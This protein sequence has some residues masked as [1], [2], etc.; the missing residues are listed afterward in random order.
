MMK[1]RLYLFFIVMV[2]G[3]L[4]ACGSNGGDLGSQS[5]SEESV[6]NSSTE[7]TTFPVTF[8]DGVQNEITI[9]EQPERIISLMPS[10]TETLFA[11]GLNDEIIGVL[12]YDNYPEEATEKEKVGDMEINLEKIIALEPDVVFAHA[13]NYAEDAFNQLHDI[14]VQVVVVNDAT[15]FQETYE[16]IDMLAMATGT[17]EQG[18]E[19]I[20]TMQDKVTQLQEKAK[21]VQEQAAVWVEVDPDLY[22]TGEQ[23]FMHEMLEMIQ[24]NNVAEDH[25]GWIQLTEE[26]VISFNPDVIVITYGD[27]IEDAKEQ[28]LAREAWQ[29]VAA[30]KNER[31]YDVDPDI[32]T[33]PGP[34]LVEGVEELAK[35][36]YPEVFG[37]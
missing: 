8:T 1:Q 34:R 31:V 28:V 12:D 26:E 2:I 3:L 30:I 25:E 21:D 24:A 18:E 33:R 23:T 13:S 6:I 16:S 37:N 15:S 4:A 19:I 27:Y 11:L 7:E 14:G 10:N 17:Q 20:T 35:A 32:V 22:T 5:D 29:T 9:S 36:I